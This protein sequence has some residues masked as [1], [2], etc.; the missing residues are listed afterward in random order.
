MNDLSCLC[1]KQNIKNLI[2]AGVGCIKASCNE[3]DAEKSRD[4]GIQSCA[5]QF[6]VN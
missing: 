3:D 6:G 2:G 1:K 5:G 4:A